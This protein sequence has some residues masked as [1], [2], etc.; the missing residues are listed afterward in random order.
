MRLRK[1]LVLSLALFVCAC[2][3]GMAHAAKTPDQYYG[4]TVREVGGNQWELSVVNTNPDAK[5]IGSFWWVPPAGMS[6]TAL[7]EVRGGSCSLTAGA[8]TCKGDVAPPNCN[9]C[10]GAAMT[11][12]F[13]ATGN[14][15]TFVKTSYGGYFIHYGVLGLLNITSLKP[16]CKA[17]QVS[18]KAKPCSA[19]T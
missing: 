11:I 13:T 17:N 6:V 1:R 14:E 18:T 3:T 9:T 19:A 2:L 8:I 5:F 4:E 7:R 15:P 10:V 12:E 16:G